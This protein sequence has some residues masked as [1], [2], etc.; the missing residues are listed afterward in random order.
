[1][2]DP[3]IFVPIYFTYKIL[4]DII[5]S[6][7]RYTRYSLDYA[8]VFKGF[9]FAFPERALT[10]SQAVQERPSL[11]FKTIFKITNENL[12]HDPL[13]PSTTRA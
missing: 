5:R 10:I 8:K 7:K 2:I 13:L 1:M 6:I 3:F 4:Q 9:I 12:T 11:G